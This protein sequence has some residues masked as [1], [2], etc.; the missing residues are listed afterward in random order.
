MIGFFLD[1]SFGKSKSHRKFNTYNKLKCDEQPFE[2]LVTRFE[3]ESSRL[4]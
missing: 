3:P 2:G 1:K 4:N